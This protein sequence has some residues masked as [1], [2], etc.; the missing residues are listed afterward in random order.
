MQANGMRVALGLLAFVCSL[1]C[2]GSENGKNDTRAARSSA[3]A[4]SANSTA[5]PSAN[6]TAN[7]RPAAYSKGRWRVLPFDELDRVVVWVS[8]IL[9]QHSELTPGDTVFGAMDISNGPPA[10]T[11]PRGAA[12]AQARLIADQARRDPAAFEQLARQHSEDRV[13][14][15]AGG[16]LGGVK[17]TQLP[18]SF[19]DALATL[20]P[21]EV[22]NVVESEY[23]Y[24]V[25]KRRRLPAAEQVAGSRIVIA[26]DNR[27]RL[28]GQEPV[29]RSRT[30]AL[31]RARTAAA[32]AR[33]GKRSFE[34]VVAEY[35]DGLDARQ[36]GD[37]GVWSV[38]DPQFMGREIELLSALKVD[39]ISEPMDSRFGFQVFKR[40]LV[41]ERK[42]YAM[43][44]VRLQFDSTASSP[45]A[46]SRKKIAKLAQ[47]LIK[48]L[49]KDPS[50]FAALQKEHCCRDQV[51]QWT[52]GR[53][54]IG[55]TDVLE[56][57]DFGQIADAAVVDDVFLV[58]PKRLD[59]ATVRPKPSPLHDF[60]TPD[61]PDF[62]KIIRHS[63]GE[64]VAAYV[65][66]LRS[67]ATA[68]LDLKEPEKSAF[69]LLL[70]RLATGLAS[71]YEPD[72]RVQIARLTGQ[73]LQVL[74]GPE[75]FAAYQR[76]LN[77]WGTA[78]VMK[79]R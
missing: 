46:P 76:F 72:A 3:A 1:G 21:G 64:A 47:Y 56:K 49:R 8:H 59:P 77:E 65:R 7:S 22:S 43:T 24:H 34:A 71:N 13:T 17:A 26:Y 28:P 31:E 69:S 74:L 2:R 61:G 15:D 4:A 41:T 6:P 78:Q 62:E 18:D 14:R 73:E 12:L 30:E 27:L 39:E 52:L 54:P 79:T 58:I 38:H 63:N 29:R 44:A 5:L 25:L 50:S 60:P 33:T 67:E 40:T 19:L 42:P 57:L 66:S 11:R 68:A 55:V 20:K 37:F 53:G 51:D 70:E 9:I 35:S 10:S 32:A 75:K 36:Q 48:K 45:D 16:S 23:G